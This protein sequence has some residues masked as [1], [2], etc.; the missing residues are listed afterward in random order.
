MIYGQCGSCKKNK[1]FVKRRS[2]HC[3]SIGQKV[4]SKNELC[5]KCFLAIKSMVN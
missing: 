4:T 1:F 2:Y 3:K 5:R